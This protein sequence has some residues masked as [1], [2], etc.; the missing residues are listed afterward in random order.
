[1]V[2]TREP[3]SQLAPRQGAPCLRVS[4]ISPC[5]PCLLVAIIKL[6]TSFNCD[7]I[8]L[9]ASPIR[10]NQSCAIVCPQNCYLCFQ[11]LCVRRFQLQAQQGLNFLLNDTFRKILNFLLNDTLKKYLTFSELQSVK[12][13][14]VSHWA[15]FYWMQVSNNFAQLAHL[16]SRGASRHSENSLELYL[17]LDAQASR[18]PTWSVCL[19][20]KFFDYY[21]EGVVLNPNPI[22]S[23]W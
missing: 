3:P 7:Q 22:A 2:W 17:F 12:T 23:T 18:R 21:K 8:H 15:W 9:S 14:L 16:K 5:P 6:P 19:L 13:T 1:M 11:G 4:R 20:V 10:A